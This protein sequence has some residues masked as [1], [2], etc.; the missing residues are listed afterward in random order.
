MI[1]TAL[2]V[3]HELA[4]GRAVVVDLD[5]QG[6]ATAWGALREAD[7]PVVVA[8]Q[9]R[10]LQ[11]VL[12]AARDGGADLVVI[13]TPPALVDAALAAARVADL[14]V[15]PC[16]PALADLH[17]IMGSLGVCR[18]AG[19]RAAVVVNAAPPAGALVDQARTALADQ[20]AE[21][22]AGDHRPAYRACPCV[23]GGADGRGVRAC[24]EGGAGDRGAV[25]LAYRP[26]GDAMKQNEIDLS[27]ALNR[28]AGGTSTR[29][30]P[31]A[32]ADRK[33]LLVRLDPD[34]MRR[35][36]HLAV[37][38]DC[39]LQALAAEAIDLLFERYEG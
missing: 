27:A 16:R 5:P 15:V 33:V 30:A 17:A 36:K 6:S 26:K 2:A 13:D 38:R 32:A 8:A 4:G 14:V 7:R 9:A 18:D 28:A 10:R 24:R 21:V 35:L 19:T 22:A 34:T 12:D 39:T 23:R 37:D 29:P 3:A 11:L 20:G 25:R 1:A 31:T